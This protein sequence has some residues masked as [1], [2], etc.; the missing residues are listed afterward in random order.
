MTSLF[1]SREFIDQNKLHVIELGGSKL[2]AGPH[3][4]TYGGYSDCEDLERMEVMASMLPTSCTVKL[5]PAS[6]DLQLFSRSM[7]VLHRAGFMV[8]YADLNYD[9]APKGIEFEDR[10][11]HAQRKKLA[12]CAR[13]G[14]RSEELEIGAW[15]QAHEL[16]VKSRDRNGWTLSLP[17]PAILRLEEARPGTYRFFATRDGKE[18]IASA[19][20]VN[21]EDDVLLIYAWGDSGKSEFAPTVHLAQA[22]Y[23]ESCFC[24]HRLLD[25]GISTVA[26]IPNMGLINF[27]QSLGFVPSI[28]VTMRR[29]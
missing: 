10:I 5:A 1:H 11:S 2:I 22:I 7:N 21:V 25:A 13:A 4:G 8:E 3:A 14:F 6:H 19:I 28:K 12:K 26:G 24:G 9:M 18:M 15:A 16:L 29:A 27:K 17:L 20:C 23:E